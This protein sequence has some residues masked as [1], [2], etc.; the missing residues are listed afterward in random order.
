MGCGLAV[1]ELVM[2]LSTGFGSNGIWLAW[3][4]LLKMKAHLF[5]VSAAGGRG[6]A[7]T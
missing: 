4:V 5:S 6:T 7:A 3:L 2:V 1:R